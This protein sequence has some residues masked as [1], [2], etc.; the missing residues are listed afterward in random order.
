MY[1]PMS[2]EPAKANRVGKADVKN[3]WSSNRLG[4]RARFKTGEKIRH[5]NAA[6]PRSR[7]I[8]LTYNSTS[9]R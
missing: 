4:Q 8:K 3:E 7:T 1:W 6:R 9:S 5:S 2:D